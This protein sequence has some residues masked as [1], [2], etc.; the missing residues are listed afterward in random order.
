MECIVVRSLK[1][2]E[3]FA[4]KFAKILKGGEVVL[5]SG[6]LGAGKTTFVKY[7]LGAL[8]VKTQITSPTFT[9]MREY[10]TKKFDIYHF[11]MYRL[12]GADEAREFGLED[13]VFSKNPRSLVFIEWAENV[14]E[15]LTGKYIKIDIKLQDENSRVISIDR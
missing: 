2:T 7:I 12:G 9:I 8:G 13:Y 4:K 3:K 6:D 14:K 1:E 5:L 10:A 11:D 15:M